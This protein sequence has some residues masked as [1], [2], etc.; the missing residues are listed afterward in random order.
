MINLVS[1]KT[2]TVVDYSGVIL[3]PK[4]I[5][6]IIVEIDNLEKRVRQGEKDGLTPKADITVMWM[7]SLT[8]KDQHKSQTGLA[9]EPPVDV[10]HRTEKPVLMKF[11]RDLSGYSWA[12][13]FGWIGQ[14]LMKGRLAIDVFEIP[15]P[16]YDGITSEVYESASEVVSRVSKLELPGKTFHFCLRGF[17]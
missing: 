3:A 13:N 4:L 12:N 15:A 2:N 1:L 6:Q 14:G 9:Y 5:R 8:K 7:D 10:S 11:F 16:L 17:I